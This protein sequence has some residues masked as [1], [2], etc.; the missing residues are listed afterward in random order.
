MEKSL[1][2]AREFTSC[3]SGIRI[4]MVSLSDDSLKDLIHE[5]FDI[6]PLAAFSETEIKKHLLHLEHHCIYMIRV[7]PGLYYIVIRTETKDDY[8]IAGPC[9]TDNLSENKVRTLLRSLHL[10]NRRIQQVITYYHWQ[11]VLSYEK[12]YQLGTLLGR[13][14]L[15]LPEPLGHRNVEYELHTDTPAPILTPDASVSHSKIREVEKRYEIST[16]ITEA[17]K[18]GNLALALQFMQNNGALSSSMIR[19]TNTLRNAKNLCIIMNTQLRHSMEEIKI[20]PYRLDVISSEIARHIE[21]LKS[22]DEAGKYFTRIIHRYCDLALE[23]NYSHT[24][25][26]SQQAVTY[27]K[28]HLADNITVK[29]TA[30]ALLVNANYLSGKFHKEMGMT[31]T[32]FVNKQRVEQA[33]SLLTKTS[34]Q[35]QQIAASVGYDNVSYFSKQFVRFYN[36]TPREYRQDNPL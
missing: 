17:V 8:L 34:M 14:I 12:L 15:Q 27:I 2:I 26:L 32:A 1:Q 7:L 23:K 13:H 33:A 6:L 16:A 3:L 10:D 25:A 29:D 9:L 24:S 4:N 35:I 11:P 5:T 22:L 28:M 18:Q 21:T 31:F 20:H 19:N 30:K 36:K